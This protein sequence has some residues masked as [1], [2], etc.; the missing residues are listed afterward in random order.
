MFMLQFGSEPTPK[1]VSVR[2]AGDQII[3][4]PIVGAVVETD[5]GWILLETGI[6]R[7][8]LEDEGARTA[9]YRSAEQPWAQVGDPLETA[10]ESVGLSVGD[11]S[12]A[13]ASHLHCDHSGGV[14][15]LARAGVPI[16]VH[17]REH[18]FAFERA[19][20]EHAYYA[21][22]YADVS[23]DWKILADEAEL[24]PGVWV[25]ETPGHTPGHLSY[26]VNLPESGTWL[27]A[28]DAADLAENLNDRVPPGWSAEVGDVIRAEQ[29]LR[30][31]LED[32]E[33]LDARLV[34]GHDQVFWNA[35]RHPR[36][37]HL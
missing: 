7:Q 8:F 13:C 36:G 3:W 23:A 5:A 31:L 9:I 4:C 19:G 37:G 11:L 16:A 12:L 10:L 24:A 22:D 28:V 14:R 21:P 30:R 26:R 34:P 32:A 20:L 35:V 27:L 33:R 15:T 29:S 18:R 17:E 2:G 1:S 6:G 25:L